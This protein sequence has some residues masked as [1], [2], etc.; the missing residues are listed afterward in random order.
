MTFIKNRI[1]HNKSRVK[2]ALVAVGWFPRRSIKIIDNT[3]NVG[4]FYIAYAYDLY[5]DLCQARLNNNSGIKGVREKPGLRLIL[6]CISCIFG[7]NAAP[8]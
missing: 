7:E 4:D 3:F 1:E 6:I 5:T 8:L 2:I